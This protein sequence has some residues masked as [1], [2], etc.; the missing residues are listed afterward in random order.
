MRGSST[1]TCRRCRDDARCMEEPSA[2]GMERRDRRGRSIGATAVIALGDDVDQLARE[3][4]LA[5]QRKLALATVPIQRE[6]IVVL[7]E[8]ET[9]ADLVRG[10]HVEVLA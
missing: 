5:V 6:R 3:R 2:G 4:T 9:V 10:D 8:S 7:V 1:R